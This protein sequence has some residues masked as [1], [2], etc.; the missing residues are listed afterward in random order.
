M[1]HQYNHTPA[2]TDRA[3]RRIDGDS[4]ERKGPGR[5]SASIQLAPQRAES[6]RKRWMR[7]A[8]AAAALCV[9]DWRQ[10]GRG[11]EGVRRQPSLMGVQPGSHCGDA[12]G[13]E[14][15]NDP[16]QSIG[17][18]WQLHIYFTAAAVCTPR[19][20]PHVAEQHMDG[21]DDARKDLTLLTGAH[22]PVPV[23]LPAPTVSK[24]RRHQ[25]ARL[26]EFPGD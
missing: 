2:H 20:V 4:D 21:G 9:L 19:G 16:F 7:E 18:C 8:G 15:Q 17:R 1:Q 3:E 22:S 14:S 11:E 13:C 6:W 26:L 10:A 12:Q 23:L 5:P 25:G 24:H